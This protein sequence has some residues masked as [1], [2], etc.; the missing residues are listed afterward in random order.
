[1]SDD[2]S[3]I[4]PQRVP[5]THTA[6][7]PDRPPAPRGPGLTWGL[8]GVLGLGLLVIVF[9]VLPRWLAETPPAPTTASDGKPAQP[10]PA[11]A[12]SGDTT[13]ATADDPGLPPYQALL[14]E[15]A[16]SQ[17][18]AE[19]SRFVE[20]QM[21]LEDEMTVGAWGSDAYD[22]A[23]DLAAEGDEAFIEE[24]FPESLAR[25]AAASEALADL[26]ER[27]HALLEDALSRGEQALAA[28]NQQ[29]AREAFEL[30]GAIAPDDPRVR[31]GRDRTAALPTIADMMREARNLELAEQW[32]QALDRYREIQALDPQTAGLETALARAEAGARQARI[33]AQLSTG[34]ARLDAGEYDQARRAFRSVLDMAPG[35][36]VA[37]GALEQVDKTAA[38]ARL[39][40]LQRRAETAV[41]EERWSDAEALYSQ[42]LADDPN[43]QFA[44]AGRNLARQQGRLSGALGRIIQAPDRLSSEKLYHEA[45]ELLA[46]AE[47]LEPRGPVLAGQIA[48]VREILATYA[49]PVPVT[50]RSDA[51]TQ[52]TLST[53]GELGQFSEKTLRLRPGAYTL[54]GSRDGCRDVREQILVRPNMPP[55]DIRCVETL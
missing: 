18:Q 44:I 19:L 29:A 40:G 41:A 4:K 30:A 43:I 28:R 36:P 39:N 9:F 48:N 49:N 35:H 53:V 8:A 13:S 17:A 26:I 10:A 54:I 7:E 37:T 23:K 34:F 12:G 50:F 45:T 32:Q 42:V 15:Q 24:N 6:Q 55:V 46:Q 14:R 27:G 16:R 33:E 2:F 47:A 1:M 20:L 22:E 11:S 51:R 31:A 3:S 21:K 38:V 5:L 52:V 25:Y